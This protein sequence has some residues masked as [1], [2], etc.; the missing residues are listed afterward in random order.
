MQADLPHTLYLKDKGKGKGK[1]EFKYNSN[2]PA[3]AKQMEAIKRS[4][5]RKAAKM[6][7]EEP[8]T[9]EELFK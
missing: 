9:T 5:E 8:F 4:Q 6:R 1:K 7:G 3:I 2:D